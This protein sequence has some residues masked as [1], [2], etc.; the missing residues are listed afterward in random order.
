[1]SVGVI[2]RSTVKFAPLATMEEVRR[3]TVE[4]GI[5]TLEVLC[6]TEVHRITIESG[7]IT[8]RDHTVESVAQ[9][10]TTAALTGEEPTITCVRIKMQLKDWRQRDLLNF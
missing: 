7:R 6:D 8:V 2:W 5:T 1:M 10:E 4:D 3:I 9:E